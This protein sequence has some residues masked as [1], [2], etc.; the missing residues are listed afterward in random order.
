MSDDEPTLDDLR[1]Q[2]PRWVFFTGINHR[3]YG[4]LPPT[5]PPVVLMGEDV[6]DLRDQIRG[7]LGRQP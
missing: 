2:F 1:R 7:Y 5:S 6:T 3:P 4:R